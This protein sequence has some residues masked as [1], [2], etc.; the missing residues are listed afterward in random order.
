MG[1][2][3][4]LDQVDFPTSNLDVSVRQL[5]FDWNDPSLVPTCTRKRVLCEAWTG[6]WFLNPVFEVHCRFPTPE[7]LAK[8]RA[9]QAAW[10]RILD[11]QFPDGGWRKKMEITRNPIDRR[12]EFTGF[13]IVNGLEADPQDWIEIERILGIRPRVTRRP[14]AFALA[15][16][17]AWDALRQIS[18]AELTAHL[19]AHPEACIFVTPGIS[20]FN[21]TA[22]S[23]FYGEAEKRSEEWHRFLRHELGNGGKDAL[24]G[25]ADWPTRMLIFNGTLAIGTELYVP[26]RWPIHRVT[27]CKLRRGPNGARTVP[28]QYLGLPISNQGEATHE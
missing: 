28:P 23:A 17:R 20:V 26:G 22:S 4:C 6:C 15:K 11:R 3:M 5:V 1:R 25:G 14:P 16:Q 2:T 7:F 8:A 24:A 13:L 21:L 27:N 18:Q 12:A 10:F 19:D 9:C